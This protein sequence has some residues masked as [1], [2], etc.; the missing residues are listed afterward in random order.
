MN[1]TPVRP[2]LSLT[3]LL[4]SL[5]LAGSSWIRLQKAQHAASEASVRRATEKVQLVEKI[6]WLQSQ[7]PRPSDGPPTRNSPPPAL[8]HT[9]ALAETMRLL[10]PDFRKLHGVSG[11]TLQLSG[12]AWGKPATIP[13]GFAEA[14]GLSPAEKRALE[15][16]L[17]ESRLR[18]GEL[19]GARAVVKQSFSQ[20]TGT[21][22]IEHSPLPEAQALETALFERF[23]EILGAERF[24]WLETISGEALRSNFYRYGAEPTTFKVTYEAGAPVRL[25]FN[26]PAAKLGVTMGVPHDI[27]EAFDFVM[28]ALP[29]DRLDPALVRPFLEDRTALGAETT[30]MRQMAADLKSQMGAEFMKAKAIPAMKA[31]AEAHGGKEPSSFVALKDLRPYFDSGADADLWAEAVDRIEAQGR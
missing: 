21:V 13:A 10:A 14:F 18:V 4:T 11:W 20:G 5:V 27:L 7:L 16:A 9:L 22:V 17:A 6:Q 23:R 2:F 19:I 29:A 30:T 1:L 15:S 24:G 28:T 8:A 25:Q 31:Y 12:G 26:Q 3:L